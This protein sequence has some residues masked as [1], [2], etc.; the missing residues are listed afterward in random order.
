[1]II[2]FR[3]VPGS[4]RLLSMNS[5]PLFGNQRGVILMK[6]LM[7]VVVT[8]LMAGLAGTSWRST[9]QQVREEEL[10]WRGDQYRKAIQSY[11]EVQFGGRQS[12]PASFDDLL[13]DPRSL[14]PVRHLR[15]LYPEPFS[16]ADWVVL[17]D[18]SGR[19]KGVHSNSMEEPFKKDGF[20]DE[21]DNF[22]EKMHYSDW[23]FIYKPTQKKVVSGSAATIRSGFPLNP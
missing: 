14:R 7:M 19:I 15:R 22:K 18:A 11:Y 6:I 5:G 1:M 13:L 4:D 8:G 9:M 2:S 23:E 10:L 16:G 12:Y 21:Y 17:K 20:S 3:L